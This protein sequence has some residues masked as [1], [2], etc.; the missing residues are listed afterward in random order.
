M[1]TITLIVVIIFFQAIQLFSQSWQHVQF[2]PEMQD[3]FIPKRV[4]HSSGNLIVTGQHKLSAYSQ[5]YK[6]TNEGVTWEIVNL[7]FWHQANSVNISEAS[8][9][10]Y[11][12]G[13]Q[14]GGMQTI[15][16][17]SST[18]ISLWQ[19]STSNGHPFN[20]RWE[21]MY[22]YQGSIYLQVFL[23]GETI[24]KMA[25]LYNGGYEIV[26]NA[27]IKGRLQML[28]FETNDLGY[29]VCDTV[30]GMTKEFKLY[31][32]T[33]GAQS[34]NEVRSL[35]SYMSGEESS[36]RMQWLNMSEGW[37]SCGQL[38]FHTTD[39][40]NQWQNLAPPQGPIYGFHFVSALEG[41]VVCNFWGLSGELMG[42]VNGG[43]SWYSTGISGFDIESSNW[44]GYAG[45]L[46]TGSNGASYFLAD[47]ELYK[48]ERLTGTSGEGS[49]IRGYELKQNY[50]NPFNPETKISYSV[51]SSGP[52]KIVIF[53][54]AGKIVKEL[55]DQPFQKMGEYSVRFDGSN[56]S[57]GVYFCKMTAKNF[58][59]IKKMMLVK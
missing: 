49:I 2:S 8:P 41:Y 35:G 11:A 20:A 1:K 36:V 32:T 39:S 9:I 22:P 7:P 3:L 12:T 56:L 48:Y 47:S 42:T 34:W 15:T 24:G 13:S 26:S 58:S 17:S 6:S 38:I 43:Q 40:G 21:Y 57:S 28:H 55:V 53:D 4:L 33:D 45:D 25:R 14:S 50:P 31:K 23:P 10:L 29:M 51:S 52:V 44:V 27:A 5:A 46:L 19:T 54:A 16:A 30:F 59:D 18:G 37:I